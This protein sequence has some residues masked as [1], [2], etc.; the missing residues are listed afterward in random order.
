MA[1]TN[2]QA[3]SGD[4]EIVSNLAV[5]TNVLF[6]DG[7][8]NK[9]GIGKTDPA[10]AIDI[11]GTVTGTTFSGNGSLLTTLNLGLASHT[12]T[13]AADRIPDLNASKITAGTLAADRIPDLNASKIT[14]GTLAA[15]RIPGLNA[16]KITAGTLVRPISTTTGYFTDKV[17][18]GTLSPEYSLSLTRAGFG[19][20]SAVVTM[21]GSGTGVFN[22]GS[23]FVGDNVVTE[24][25]C[26]YNPTA[27][28]SYTYKS[29]YVQFIQ[30]K[31]RGTGILGISGIKTYASGGTSAF[32]SA[33]GSSTVLTVQ[34][35]VAN[36]SYTARVFYRA[37]DTP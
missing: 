12:G 36:I 8:N 3:F 4:V 18:I 21:N 28:S 29:G 16:S 31:V 13:L 20:Q 27:E 11:N 33:S 34:Y 37:C 14:A 10:T 15:D 24:C 35:A 22:F 9:V 17:G 32:L 1:S 19:V 26:V 23:L 30:L 6:V 25:I 2:V 7:V 5:N